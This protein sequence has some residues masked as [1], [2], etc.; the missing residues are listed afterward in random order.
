MESTPVIDGGGVLGTKVTQPRRVLDTFDLPKSV[1]RVQ[2]ISDEVTSNCPIT[3]QP[4]WYVVT[5]ALNASKKGLESKSLKLYLQSFREDG[6]FC[7]AFA[8]TIAKDV[9]E[10]TRAG[11]VQAIVKQKP[12]GGVAIHSVATLNQGR[13]WQ[14]PVTHVQS[15]PVPPSILQVM[16]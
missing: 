13:S 7:E 4:D 14:D 3:G 2:Y 9:Y 5:I 6:Q 12:R 16:K 15:M 8:D 10:V 11:A 1:D